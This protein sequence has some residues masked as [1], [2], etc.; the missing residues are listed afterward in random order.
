MLSGRERVDNLV[1]K[2]RPRLRLIILILLKGPSYILDNRERVD[3]FIKGGRL[4]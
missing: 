1:E 3:N 4:C 2:G